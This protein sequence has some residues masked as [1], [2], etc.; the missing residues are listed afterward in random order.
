M[1]FFLFACVGNLAYV[2]SIVAY[3]PRCEGGAGASSAGNVR[4]ANGAWGRVYGRYVLVNTSWLIGSAGTLMLDLMI[5]GQ[6]Y[7]YKGRKG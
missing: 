5:F 7:K 1:L 2:L 6:F 3:Q 4:C